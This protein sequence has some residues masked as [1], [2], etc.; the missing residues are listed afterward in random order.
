MDQSPPRLKSIPIQRKQKRKGAKAGDEA[1]SRQREPGETQDDITESEDDELLDD[2]KTPE[3]AIVKVPEKPN[4][5]PPDDCPP[6]M[7]SSLNW[8]A[9]RIKYNIKL[10]LASL[11]EVVNRTADAL[12]RLEG[13]VADTEDHMKKIKDNLK[14]QELRVKVLEDAYQELKQMML[15]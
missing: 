4:E 11:A 3:P 5:M 13:R 6:W 7:T 12:V 10:D 9:A 8:Q 1:G 15:N 2:A 14:A